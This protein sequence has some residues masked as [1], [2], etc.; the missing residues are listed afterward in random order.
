MNLEALA[1]KL[2]KT[3]YKYVHKRV[4]SPLYQHFIIEGIS[5]H[6][7]KAIKFP[8]PV[9][10]IHIDGELAFV[11]A[12]FQ[13]LKKLTIEALKGNG[14]FMLDLLHDAYAIN[15]EVE[16]FCKE[17]ENIDYTKVSK[18]K[19]LEYW[20]S[21]VEKLYRFGAY[22]VFPLFIEE[23]MESSLKKEVKKVF[24][25]EECDKVFQVLTTPIKAGVIQAEEGSLLKLAQQKKSGA[26]IS[27]LLKHHLI[28]FSWI[29]NNKF[30]GSFYTKEEILERLE[31]LVNENPEEKLKEYQN[32]I[33]AFQDQFNAYKSTFQS[34]ETQ[35][36]IDTLQE[37]IYFRSWRTERYYRNAYFLQD[38]FRRTSE[39]LN[40]QK[41][42][43]VFYLTSE[44]IL[45]GLRSG[46]LPSNEKIEKRRIG[47]FSYADT[48]DIILLSGA[49]A[50]IFRKAVVVNPIESKTEIKGQV[51]FPGKATGPARIVTSMAQLH[52][53]QEGD[54]LITTSTT[55]DYVPVLKKVKA[56]VTEEGGVLSHASVISRELHIPCIIG[57]KVATKVLKDGDMIEVDANTGIV[58]ILK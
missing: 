26:D 44:E 25:A 34:K 57:T 32:K 40:L 8:Y 47:Y 46:Q 42:D 1:D 14:R 58:R 31:K 22:V 41:V 24:P 20:S 50:D 3:K 11:D 49:D 4:R 9:S 56:I 35:E 45:T 21:Y 5:K 39:V 43:D 53:V 10:I 12:D 52:L 23:Y 48:K 51:A 55:P 19:I 54:I 15:E 13:N 18:E 2:S 28:D 30:T 33:K 27:E 6:H 16:K 17:L 38:F 37:S 7:N 36:L 29:K